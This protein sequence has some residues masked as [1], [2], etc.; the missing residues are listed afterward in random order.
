MAL[1]SHN[2]P[3]HRYRMWN[4]YN[5]P[6][7]HD[8]QHILDWCAQVASEVEGGL[9]AIVINCH[10]FYGDHWWKGGTGGFGLDMG[11]GIGRADTGKF[12]VLRGKVEEIW[13]TACGAARISIPG[14]T[15]DGDGNLFCCEIA[16][17]SGAYV[18]A[19][20]QIQMRA[21]FVPENCIDSY[22]GKVLRYDPSGGVEPMMQILEA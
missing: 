13:I 8:P 1:N 19:S 21:L 22:E 7:N 2:V 9:K 11:T 5:V 14:T 16:K 6:E 12:A 4:T 18:M 17:Q 10:G 15:G 20:P 3:G